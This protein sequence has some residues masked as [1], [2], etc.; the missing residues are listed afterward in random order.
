MAHDEIFKQFTNMF[1]IVA[2]TLYE[3]F[4]NGKN[5]IRVRLN[6]GSDF[7]FTFFDSCDW[8]YETIDS[9]IKKMKGGASMKC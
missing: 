7:V 2:P 4:P 1:P 8:C 9:Y 3:W 5:S 6:C